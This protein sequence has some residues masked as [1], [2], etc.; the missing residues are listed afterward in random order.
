MKK[1]FSF[2]LFISL[3]LISSCTINSKYPD[4]L[5]DFEANIDLP[6]DTEADI[7]ILI[8]G[9]NVNET[10]MIEKAI[11][12]FNLKYPNINISLGYVSVGSYENTVRNQA[13][14]GSLPDIVWT[15]SPDF[16]FLVDKNIAL[17]L[18][19]YIDLSEEAGIFDL[20]TDFYKEY[21]DIGSVDDKHYVVPRSADSVVTFYNKKLLEEAGV[22]LTLIENGWSWDTF[23]DVCLQVREY[24]DSKGHT[25][26][27]VLDANLTTWLSVNYPILR[28]MGADITDGTG[29]LTIDSEETREALELVKRMLDERIIVPT[30][31]TP[32]SSFEAGTSAFLF[33]SASVSLFAERK[34]LKGNIDIVSF[35]LI[36]ENPKI[37]T[38]IAGYS[39]NSASAYKDEAWAF[40]NYLISYEG[41]QNMAL[42]GLNTPSIRQDL[43]DYTTA[44]W[45]EGY[46]EFNLDAYLYGMEYKIAPD[47]FQY[48]DAKY[49]S[50][51][52]LALR[53]LFNNV[54]N[55]NKTIE[56]SIA[57]AVRDMEDALES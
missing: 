48:Y 24:L 37:G 57:T 1:I 17:P 13:L 28:S 36:G 41:Q 22:N 10:S 21:F 16:Y 42:G 31:I 40:L 34:E 19:Q 49:K 32:G 53:D 4:D 47:F 52:D 38:G 14:A 43:A 11:E 23:M 12:G 55:K 56:E 50:D 29:K 35:P 26:R 33:Q 30:G 9:G 25:D 6:S 20:E 46:R 2:I 18:N 44:N 27:Y 54:C 15:N 3:L 39:I 45:G 7:S 51:L 8:P 5:D